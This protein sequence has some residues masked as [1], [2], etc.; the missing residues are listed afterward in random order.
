MKQNER[1]LVY[2][3]TG[4]LAII[5]VVAV[6]FGRDPAT[7]NPGA[8]SPGTNKSGQGTGTVGLT[9]I[10]NP[11]KTP[12]EGG[13]APGGKTDDANVAGLPGP[14]KV[15]GEGPLVASNKPMIAAD[16]V[17]QALGPSRRDRLARFVRA[18]S[19]DSLESLVRRWCGERDP[20][21]DEAKSLNEE[22]TVVR[23]G[24]EVAVPWV[25]DEVVLAAFEA[26]QPKKLVAEA[27]DKTDAGSPA[28]HEGV[29]N[30]GNTGT[31]A[32]LLKNG[33]RSQPVGNTPVVNQPSFAT[34]G[35]N[36]ADPEPAGATPGG[37]AP[38]A[39][40]PVAGRTRTYT[41]KSGDSPWKI[42]EKLYGRK[43]ADRMVSEI[44][45]LNP[46]KADSLRPDQKLVV[47]EP[48]SAPATTPSGT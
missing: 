35:G 16:L 34:P 21:L 42:A 2:A 9:D 15:S 24:Q 37:A 10:M 43:N 44:R 6:L 47:P 4:F 7:A 26:R 29:V 17:A 8:G 22:L 41:V 39:A 31:V 38:A 40:P 5:L 30:P 12:A 25:D 19:G 20:F 23:V 32:A 45:R 48:V 13:K 18:R 33:E 28:N 1:I 27:S 3:V 46:G 11:S 14:E 36:K